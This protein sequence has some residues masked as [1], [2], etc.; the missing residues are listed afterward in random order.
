MK[1]DFL[2]LVFMTDN[3]L[4]SDGSFDYDK[5]EPTEKALYEIASDAVADVQKRIPLPVFTKTMS[6]Y[7]NLDS[8][9][10]EK[11]RIHRF[12]AVRVYARYPSGKEAW[13]NLEPGYFDSKLDVTGKE[14]SDRLFFLYQGKFG[15]PSLICEILPPLCHLSKWTWLGVAA[16]SAYKASNTQ[17]AA[18]LLW[19]GGT[20]IGLHEFA[21]R[22]GLDPQ[23]KLDG[24][25]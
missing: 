23:S 17:G 21:K 14:I 2:E 1:A 9:Q 3:P 12:P 6:K 16:F 10:F 11:W 22:G 19:L 13:Y 4:L 20:G 24:N 15:T 5:L 18:R 8:V 7:A 25:G